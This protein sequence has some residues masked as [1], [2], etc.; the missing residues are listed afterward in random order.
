MSYL[1]HN[2]EKSQPSPALI[3]KATIG[4]AV[5]S[6]VEW[7]DVAVYG[8][9]AATIGQVFFAISDPTV[10]LL[11]SF[12]V[13]GAAFVVRPLGGLY[14]GMLGD[15]IGRQKTLA[16]V[17]LLV[18]AATF[19]IGIVPGYA[20]IGILAPILLVL[21]RLLQGFSAGG[22][23]GGASAF[24]AE[25]A[26]PKRRGYL[27]SFVEMGAIA[28][29]LLGS[30]V[31]LTLNFSLSQHDL[32]EWGWRIPFLLAAPMGLVGLFIRNK[33][34]ET[35]EFEALRSSG[36]V[37]KNPLKQTITHHW[38]AVLVVGGFALFQN[39][40]VYI[41]LTFL[42]TH[43]SSNLKY[44]A[45]IGSISSV[46]T[47]VA[48]CIVIPLT[49]ALSDRIGRKKV[50]GTSCVAA[51]VLA[52]PLFVLME[53]GSVAAIAGHVGLGIILGIFLGP[54][55]PAMNEMFSTEVRYGGFSLGYNLSAS[56]F[57]GTAPFL[58]TLL[59]ANTG[60]TASPSFYIIAAALVTFFVLVATK[61]TA[62][63]ILESRAKARES[64]GA[65]TPVL[66]GRETA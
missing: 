12:A 18:S 21:L 23:L 1:P 27:V 2:Q 15:R 30:V 51:I 11:S 22:E 44:G 61:E 45:Q 58:V 25:Y 55:L 53:Q 41:I 7:F 60:I 63:R 29:F 28:G 36:K 24:V 34:E 65:G 9:L 39:A 49:G 64:A 16:A 4:A 35:P 66:E 56:L 33:L 38:K 59:I 13:F 57:G 50:L 17:L 32:L 6:V 10:A 31:V 19:G 52:Y 42:A 20:S 48:V 46:I 40:A 14:F 62:P 5:G 8:Y 54:V 37:L 43:I 26:P 47:M 3:R